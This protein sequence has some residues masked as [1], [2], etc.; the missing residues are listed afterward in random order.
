MIVAEPPGGAGQPRR[1]GPASGGERDYSTGVPLIRAVHLV[2]VAL[3][4]PAVG[5]APSGGADL[6]PVLTSTPFGAIGGQAVVHTIVV[7]GSGTGSVAGVRLTFT[8]NVSLDGATVSTSQGQCSVTDARTVT[9][10]LGAVD[11]ANAD[12]PPKVTINGT[13]AP[14]TPGGTL[15][16]NLVK[17]T[18]GA[19]DGDMSNNATSNAYLIPGGSGGPPGRAEAGR[20]PDRSGRTPRFLAQVAGGLL[21]FGGLLTLVLVRRRRR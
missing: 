13:V 12:A 16:Q 19:P 17:L 9:C 6:V 1:A 7:S 11:V 4:G 18:P 15:V 14:G 20:P 2:A 8:T 10:D 21:A 3:G 5:L